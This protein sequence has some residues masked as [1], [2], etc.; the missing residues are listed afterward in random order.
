VLLVE[1]DS[2]SLEEVDVVVVSSSDKHAP[3]YCPAYDFSQHSRRVSNVSRD[4]GMGT[5]VIHFPLP[6]SGFR[7]GYHF[8]FACDQVDTC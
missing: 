7:S 1:A 8:G 6:Q 4:G 2:F 3:E 5:V